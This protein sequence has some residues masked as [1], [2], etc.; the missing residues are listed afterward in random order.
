MGYRKVRFYRNGDRFDPGKVMIVNKK[1][2]GSWDALLEELS[3]RVLAGKGV[4]RVYSLERNQKISE[5]RDLQDGGEYVCVG[6]EGRLI[7]LEYRKNKAPVWKITDRK[8]RR[9]DSGGG[10]FVSPTKK[11]KRLSSGASAPFSYEVP[12]I[13]KITVYKNDSFDQQKKVTVILTKRSA[14]SLEQVLAQLSAMYVFPDGVRKLYTLDGTLVTDVQTLKGAGASEFVAVGRETFKKINRLKNRPPQKFF[15]GGRAPLP[16]IGDNIYNVHSAVNDPRLSEGAFRPN[17]QKKSNP[18]SSPQKRPAPQFN[19]EVGGSKPLPPIGHDADSG[20]EDE[21]DE[22]ND[23]S[24]TGVSALEPKQYEHVVDGADSGPIN[25]QPSLDD[26]GASDEPNENRLEGAVDQLVEASGAPDEAAVQERARQERQTQERLAEKKARVEATEDVVAE[27]DQLDSVIKGEEA[28]QAEVLK[29][30]RMEKEKLKFVKEV[31]EIGH[32]GANPIDQESEE[33]VD[34][35]K[36]VAA[37]VGLESQGPKEE[38]KEEEVKEINTE[39]ISTHTDS[40]LQASAA[41]QGEV[42]AED[43]SGPQQE[44]RQQSYEAPSDDVRPED[45]NAPPSNPDDSAEAGSGLDNLISSMEKELEENLNDGL[46]NVENDMGL[47]DNNNGE[48]PGGSLDGIDEQNSEDAAAE[49]LHESVKPFQIN[50]SRPVEEVYDISLEEIGEGQYGVVKLCIHK[51]SGKKY[52]LKS[53]KKEN[54]TEEELQLL[55]NEIKVHLLVSHPLCVELNDVFNTDSE[56]H[57]VMELAEGGDLFDSIVEASNRN[58]FTEVDA[59]NK[60]RD[61]LTAVEYLH[62]K[63]I[64]HRDLKPENLL[65]EPHKTDSNT[66]SI[67]VADFGLSKIIPDDTLC[68]D[69]AGTPTYLAPEM[70]NGE[71]YGKSIDIWAIGVISYIVL[72]GRPPFGNA[73][74][75]QKSVFEKIKNADFDFKGSE[76]DSVSDGAKDFIKHLLVVNAALRP[77]A[78]QA[79]SHAWLKQ[80]GPNDNYPNLRKNITANILK[81]FPTRQKWRTALAIMSAVQKIPSLKGLHLKT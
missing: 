17:A 1:N 50:S 67:K 5:L 43:E 62:R 39:E 58:S 15:C 54:L 72:S 18:I 23:G 13:K 81:N 31:D 70:I 45:E 78:T 3:F 34:S 30:K 27:S 26:R 66:D 32:D 64:M 48:K 57:L 2:F 40:N 79:L 19:F 52:A 75:Q 41:S 36:A 44:V 12:K 47:Q 9:G 38:V 77:S 69:A 14:Q 55:E 51:E 59:A 11:R 35:S 33:E 37:G 24:V 71:G 42:K 6:T 74:G 21:Q 16:R 53:I 22:E 63:N 76:W 49:R 28:R 68:H 29:A 46:K 4:R 73:A 8:P 20:S 7:G 80:F 10:L 56:T 25:G 61:V 65:I 60:I